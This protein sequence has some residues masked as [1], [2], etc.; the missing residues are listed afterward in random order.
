MLDF[1]FGCQRQYVIGELQS[2]K[3][4]EQ[5]QGSI[6]GR[7]S[8]RHENTPSVLRSRKTDNIT[9]EKTP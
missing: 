1:A 4:W 5:V 7:S 6:P 8:L 2:S 3:I 9:S